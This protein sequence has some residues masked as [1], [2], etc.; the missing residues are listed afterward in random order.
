[1]GNSGLYLRGSHGRRCGD[2]VAVTSANTTPP[3]PTTTPAA[4]SPYCLTRHNLCQFLQ[5]GN[6]AGE[7]LGAVREVWGVLSGA[8]GRRRGPKRAQRAN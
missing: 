8:S 3:P 5:Q 2:A 1:M 6:E 4:T 7:G